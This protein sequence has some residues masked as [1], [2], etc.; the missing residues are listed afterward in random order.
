MVTSEVSLK[1]PMKVLTIAGTTSA[2]RLRQHDLA[3][4]LP[5]AQAE[6]LGRL[7]LALGQRLQPAAHHLGQV[8]R[9]EQRHA[10]QHAQQH[11]DRDCPAA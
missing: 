3:L 8:G 5:V 7:D 11:V 1:A 2:Q 9:G 6:R 10:D 4:R